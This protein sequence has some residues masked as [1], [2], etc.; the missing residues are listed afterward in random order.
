MSQPILI[1]SSCDTRAAS[2]RIAQ[3]LVAERLAACVNIVPGATSIYRW[4]GTIETAS[5]HLLLIKTTEE[6]AATV[7]KRVSELHS[8]E[9]PELLKLAIHGGS[10]KYIE[11]LVASVGNGPEP[12]QF[13]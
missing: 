9:T 10:Q 6:A 5:E 7:E 12:E 1:L 13:A 2:E 3:A 4:R 11:W 8:Y